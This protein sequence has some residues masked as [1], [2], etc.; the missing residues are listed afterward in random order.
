MDLCVCVCV[1]V[2]RDQY[3]FSAGEEGLKVLLLQRGCSR[4]DS[5]MEPLSSCPRNVA[6]PLRREEK[7]NEGRRL[8]FGFETANAEEGRMKND[9][10]NKGRSGL[11]GQVP[12]QPCLTAHLLFFS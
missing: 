3:M 8:W 9:Y 5:I 12:A 7:N 2:A 10:G 6:V 11:S 4:D 1:C